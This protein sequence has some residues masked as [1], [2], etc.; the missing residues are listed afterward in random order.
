VSRARDHRK[1][2]APAD[3]SQGGGRYVLPGQVRVLAA[4]LRQRVRSGQR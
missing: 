1:L 3:V 4:C 2:G